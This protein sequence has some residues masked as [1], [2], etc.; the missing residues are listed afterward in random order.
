MPA[1][2][3]TVK[4]MVD[5]IKL[6]EAGVK[7]NTS[8]LWANQPLIIKTKHT[9]DSSHNLLEALAEKLKHH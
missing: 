6:M 5:K 4:S 3:K 9:M 1:A 2:G 8:I 7:D